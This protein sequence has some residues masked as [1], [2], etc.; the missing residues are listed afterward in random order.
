[1][2]IKSPAMSIAGLLGRAIQTSYIGSKLFYI[3]PTMDVMQLPS[4]TI[5]YQI[6]IFLLSGRTIGSP[7]LHPNAF[8]NAGAFNTIAF[9]RANG[10]A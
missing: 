2:N 5:N 10:D 8:A 7:S 1:M 6:V 9:T 4:T 3:R